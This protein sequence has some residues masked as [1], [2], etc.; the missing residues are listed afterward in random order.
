M[1]IVSKWGLKSKLQEID[2]LAKEATKLGICET[3]FRRLD[4]EVI[5]ALDD[6]TKVSPSQLAERARGSRTHHPPPFCILKIYSTLKPDHLTTDNPS[7]L[8]DD[9]DYIYKPQSKSGRG[10]QRTPKDQ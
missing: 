6:S 1:C 3:W 10:D 7:R 2:L 9:K 4:T 5:H 8:H